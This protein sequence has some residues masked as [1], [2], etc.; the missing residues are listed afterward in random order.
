ML[1]T[2]RTLILSND[3]CALATASDNQPHCSLMSYLPSADVGE[4]YLLT[5]RSTKKYRNCLRNPSVSLLI[6]TRS[7]NAN[8]AWAVSALTLEGESR[9]P[10]TNEERE[11]I[12]QE[13]VERLPHL[14]RLAG[15]PDS[16]VLIVRLRSALLL[17]GVENSHFEA[18]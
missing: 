9:Q 16:E 18:L 8:S 3:T 14:A 4:L 2:I 6:D 11:R 7:R 12:K 15:H 5:S 13:M 10:A 1:E 17:D